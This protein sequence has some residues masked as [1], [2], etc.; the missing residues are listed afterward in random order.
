MDRVS[1]RYGSK[2]F[3]GLKT[4]Q[5]FKCLI[6]KILITVMK[7]VSQKTNMLIKEIIVGVSLTRIIYFPMSL[8]IPSTPL[9][10]I[11]YIIYYR[12]DLRVTNKVPKI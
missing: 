9:R 7:I 1:L 8:V 4:Y 6:I 3:K 10:F 2:E 12:T 11:K 5:H